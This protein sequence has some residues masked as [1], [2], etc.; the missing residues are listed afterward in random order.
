MVDLIGGE[1]GFLQK[2]AGTVR[3][4]RPRGGARASRSAG[5]SPAHGSMIRPA[6]GSGLRSGTGRRLT[7]RLRLTSWPLGGAASSP[8]PRDRCRC[9]R[10]RPGACHH[11]MTGCHSDRRRGRPDARP[12]AADRRGRP[13]R[14]RRSAPAAP[15][16][17]RPTTPRH[18]SIMPSPA[19]CQSRSLVPRARRADEPP[20]SSRTRPH[21][22]AGR[23][24]RSTPR[25]LDVGA[26]VDQRP[27]HLDVIAAGRPV[28]RRLGVPASFHRGAGIGAA[29]DQDG[30]DL[31]PAREEPRPVGRGVQRRS[32]AAFVVND[33]RRG[34]AWMLS[35][36]PSA[37][38]PHQ[39][40]SPAPGPAQAASSWTAS[41]LLA[42]TTL[43]AVPS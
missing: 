38:R 40:G 34:Q 18:G 3:H 19:A 28:Q 31:R 24:R 36:A 35:A 7:G 39:H 9:R 5:S 13:A 32:R 6:D 20:A 43:G 17:S 8:E 26:A 14:T 25:R 15:A 16:D 30:D 10:R 37:T 33:S 12:Y 11:P 2:T 23:R 22:R 29:V 1:H 21:H 41:A 27:G 4:V 42:M